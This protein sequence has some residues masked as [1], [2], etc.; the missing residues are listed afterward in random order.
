MIDTEGDYRLPPHQCC[1]SHRLNLVA[2]VDT[3]SANYDS[4]FKR[5]SRAAHAKCNALLNKQ[6]RS[7]LDSHTIKCFCGKLF[8]PPNDTRW[9]SSYDT[10]RSIHKQVDKHDDNLDEL[11]DQIGLPRFTSDDV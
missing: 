6:G 2:T 7:N 8:H 3:E 1:A 5:K 11:M 10:I 9:N 4:I